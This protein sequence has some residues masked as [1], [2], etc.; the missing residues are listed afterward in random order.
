[1]M[2]RKPKKT[3][4]RKLYLAYLIDT[5]KHNLVSL[6][7]KTGMPKRT[8]QASMK[9]FEDVGISF[10]FVQK[11]GALNKQGHYIIT[12]W[13]D[14]DKKWIKDNLLNMVDVLQ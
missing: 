12:G 13:G 7:E 10:E 5:Q 6:V 3:Y 2:I 9:A 11:E 14:H 8:I 1:M 4:Y